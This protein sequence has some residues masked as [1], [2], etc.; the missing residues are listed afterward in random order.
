[1]AVV[2]I[3][4]SGGRPCEFEEREEEKEVGERAHLSTQSGGSQVIRSEPAL[5]DHFSTNCRRRVTFVGSER[6]ANASRTVSGSATSGRSTN[7]LESLKMD[8]FWT[9][10]R[11]SP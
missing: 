3:T 5:R 9:V 10:A 11:R 2:N 6:L 8:A 1:M 7:S 4:N